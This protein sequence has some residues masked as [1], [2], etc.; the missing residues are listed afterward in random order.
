MGAFNLVVERFADIMQQTCSSCN[1]GVKTQFGSHHTGKV[2]NFQRVVED[3]LSIA[4][5]VTQP[6][7]QLNKLMVN[8]VY[9]GSKHGAFA[10]GFNGRIHF[11][12]GF[13]NRLLNSGR[14]DSAIRDQLFKGD[15]CHFTSYGLKARKR[16]GFRCVIDDEIHAGKLFNGADVTAFAADDSALHFIVGQRNDAD[17]GFGYVIRRAALNGDRND[18][19]CQLVAFFLRLLFIL[20]YFNGLFM[21]KIILK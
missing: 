12:A 10:L 11:A 16:N 14:V 5:A 13:L 4:G 17:G 3:I 18:L 8:A 2:R 19:S 9:A 7:K 21:H 15:S 20:H 1:G 6:T